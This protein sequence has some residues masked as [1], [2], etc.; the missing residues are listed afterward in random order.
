MATDFDVDLTGGLTIG[1]IGPIGPIGPITGPLPRIVVGIDQLQ[2]P[3]IQVGLD[4]LSLGITAVPPIDVGITTLPPVSVGITEVP[5][6]SVGITELPPIR[7]EPIELRLTEFPSI[8]AHLPADFHVGISFLGHELV[9]VRLCGEAQ[10][11]TEPYVP[12]PCE[13]CEPPQTVVERDR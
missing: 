5:P 8:R 1:V 12:N 9:G 4:A 13:R 3:K 10:A 2:L 11:I 7:L 6:I